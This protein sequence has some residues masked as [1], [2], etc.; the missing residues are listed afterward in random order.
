MDLLEENVNKPRVSYYNTPDGFKDTPEDQRMIKKMINV[1]RALSKGRGSVQIRH[2]TN[3]PPLDV[4]YE[5]PPLNTVTIVID[6]PTKKQLKNGEDITYIF[7]VVGK[8][9]YTFHNFETQGDTD[10]DSF[11]MHKG[12]AISFVYKKKFDNFGVNISS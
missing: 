7:D 9:K 11:M 8:V 12:H 4:S 2:G 3:Y 6:Y 5:L 10:I 1:Y